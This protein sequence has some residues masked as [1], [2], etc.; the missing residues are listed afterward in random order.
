MSDQ[1]KPLFEGIDE[2]ERTY[3]PEE[4]PEDDP[5]YKRANLDKGPGESNTS[6]LEPPIA[7]PVGVLGTAP[8]GA[9]VPIIKPKDQGVSNIDDEESSPPYEDET[10]EEEA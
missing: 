5:E 7:G 3:A 1:D 4:L 9:I 10:P 2:Y 8:T 6:D